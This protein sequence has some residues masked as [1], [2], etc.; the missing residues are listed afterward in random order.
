MHKT[1]AIEG[2]VL[3]E[4]ID[5]LPA[6]RPA[7]SQ[8]VG[9]LFRTDDPVEVVERAT[10]AAN[11]LMDVV[12]TKGL[13]SQIQG[14]E[15]LNVEAWTTLGAMVGLSARTEWSKPLLSPDGK[16]YGFEAAVEVVNSQGVI[17][18]R[19]EAQ[20][21]RGERT[22]ANRDDYALRSMAQTRAM[23]KALRMPLGFIAVLAGYEATPM[24]EM[25]DPS[26]VRRPTTTTSEPDLPEK[27]KAALLKKLRE[28]LDGRAEPEWQEPAII[29]AG[30]RQWGT[31]Y[32]SLDDFTAKH[33][34]F[35][36]EAVPA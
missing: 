25:P 2:E 15:Y 18:G 27:A 5:N 8:A 4:T 23:G 9:G 7:A 26:E 35:V 1:E 30:N 24:E 31:H 32:K 17:V 11:A 6:E 29:E 12:R 33:L 21:T 20:C 36:L 3:E 19:S 10:R 28:A 16:V 13:S 22:W 34:K 14:R